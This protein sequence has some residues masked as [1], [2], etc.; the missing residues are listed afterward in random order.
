MS[1]SRSLAVAVAVA[2][3]AGVLSL[4][5]AA[6]ARVTVRAGAKS[7]Q[8][9]FPVASRLCAEVAE[10]VR[11]PV[12]RRSAARVRVDCALLKRRFHA[13][14]TAVIAARTAFLA[15]RAAEHAATV[16]TCAGPAA[17]SHACLLARVR[18]TR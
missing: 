1:P 10:G 12:L 14:R 11:H 3:T 6:D 2:A 8:Q 5:A 18:E 13:A 17:R 4:P 15:M 16:L 7:F 9:T